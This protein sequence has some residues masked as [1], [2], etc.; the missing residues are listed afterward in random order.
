[1]R[2]SLVVGVVL[3]AI[4]LGCGSSSSPGD[5]GG[6]GGAGAGIDAAATG[7]A[8]GGSGGGGQGGSGTGGAA[9][10]TGGS[11]T[12]GAGGTATGGAGGMA[13]GGTG[14]MGTGGAGTGGGGGAATGGAGGAGTGGA[15]G[16]GAPCGGLLGRSC[17]GGQWCDYPGDTCG[18]G[19]QQGVCRPEEPSIVNCGPPVCGCNGKAYPNAC[20][21]HR[22][23]VDTIST[24][25]CIP[26][27]G[28]QNVPCGVDAD[29]QA[30]FKCCESGGSLNS[31]LICKQLP[32][33]VACPAVP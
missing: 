29:C 8:S 2:A 15:G 33:G 31:S 16:Q 3:G 1:M 13:T 5:G 27:N 32:A 18:A 14:G 28:G 23:N 4:G 24:R 17:M 6:T 30:G 7:G 22:V 20:R 26:G 19:D 12:G 25:S 11:A 21:A 9:G 10:G